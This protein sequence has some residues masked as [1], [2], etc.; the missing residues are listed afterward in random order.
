MYTIAKNSPVW[1][2]EPMSFKNSI[3]EDTS[4]WESGPREAVNCFLLA[5][6]FSDGAG[7]RNVMIFVEQVRSGIYYRRQLSVITNEVLATI[8][9]QTWKLIRWD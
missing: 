4:R 7:Y 2:V 9:P 8:G 3:F 6:V 1:E 5:R